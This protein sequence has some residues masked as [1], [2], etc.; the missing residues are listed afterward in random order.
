MTRTTITAAF[1]VM[2]FVSSMGFTNDTEARKWKKR[3]PNRIQNVIIASDL[4]NKAN[5][6]VQPTDPALAGGDRDQTLQFGDFLLGTKKDDLIIGKLGTDI[7]LGKD[8]NDV[9]VGGTEDFNPFNRDRAFGGSGHDIFLWAPGDGSDLFEGGQGWD[10]VMFGKIGEIAESGNIEFNVSPPGT[11]G[12]QN[13]DPIFL[14]PLT[15]LPL[16]DVSQSPGFCEIID[17]SNAEGGKDA[18]DALGIDHLVKFL[19]RGVADAFENGTQNIDNGLRVTL[20]LKDVETLVCTN[21][22]GGLIQVYDLT[23]SPPQEIDLDQIR[24]KKLRKRIKSMVF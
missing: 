2:I 21:R 12:S 10:A 22:D 8:G 1:T 13:S 17:E 5:P 9:L 20:H 3:Q 24:N 19:I 6:T 18:L 16:M 15:N 14:N 11:P 4:N 23:Q 7:L